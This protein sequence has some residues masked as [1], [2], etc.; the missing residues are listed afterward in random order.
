LAS[1]ASPKYHRPDGD[2]LE[3]VAQSTLGKDPFNTVNGIV[4]ALMG[5]GVLSDQEGKI[6]LDK[7]A[8]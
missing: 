2:D 8:R 5:K 4:V 3:S 1:G 6:I 7:L